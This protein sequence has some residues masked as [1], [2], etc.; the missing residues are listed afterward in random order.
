[1][2][3]TAMTIRNM[4]PNIVSMSSGLLIAFPASA[5]PVAARHDPSQ[6]AADIMMSPPNQQARA[7]SE[8]TRRSYSFP[9]NPAANRAGFPY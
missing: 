4:I 2:A 1:M 6:G 5:N 9:L 7:A 8:Y 3:P